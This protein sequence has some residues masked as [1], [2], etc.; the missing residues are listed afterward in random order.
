MDL[1]QALALGIVAAAAA[2]LAFRYLRGGRKPKFRQ[3]A[4]CPAASTHA[5]A[6]QAGGTGSGQDGD[7]TS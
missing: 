3:C 1:Q 4:D 2:L 7:A 6:K 5:P